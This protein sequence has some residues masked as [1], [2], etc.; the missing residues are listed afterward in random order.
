[1]Q[2]LG[3][4]AMRSTWLHWPILT[5]YRAVSGHWSW[6]CSGRCGASSIAWPWRDQV[7]RRALR[8]WRW[9]EATTKHMA[10]SS[11]IVMVT[12]TAVGG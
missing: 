11:F 8:R 3:D 5:T 1:M 9:A 2:R 7:H 4:S 12:A 6:Q 10:R